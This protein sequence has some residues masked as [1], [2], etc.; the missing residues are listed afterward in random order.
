MPTFAATQLRSVAKTILSAV[1]APP[2]HARLVGDS[3]VA[4]NLCGHDSHGVMRLASYAA[5]VRSGQIV[6]AAQPSIAVRQGAVARV[7]GAWGWGQV[8]AQLATSVTIELA[9]EAGIAGTTVDHCNHIGRLG[10]YAEMIATAGMIG[11]ALCNSSPIVAPYGGRGRVL[12]TNPLAIAAPRAAGAEPLLV[13]FATAGVAEGK[14]RVARANGQQ[15]APGL[16]LDAA[17]RPSQDPQAFYDGGVLLPFGGH[18]GFG[19][20]M[21]IEL[22]GGVL[23]GIAPSAVPAYRGGNGTLLMALN[24]AAFSPVDRYYDQVEQLCATIKHSPPAEGFDEV[25]LPGEPER[26]AR[27]LRS[28]Q[29]ISLADQ[30]WREIAE[31]A[32]G[33]GVELDGEQAGRG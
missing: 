21:M 17:G 22:L 13:D 8:A 1:G 30:T 25:L 31:L 18:K 11:I 4:A 16:V 19:L 15:V 2:E 6:P 26:R 10:Q 12:G 24:I 7:D 9:Q 28:E 5:L 27:A 32:A 14:L 33:L 23:S 3:L 29:G 20:S